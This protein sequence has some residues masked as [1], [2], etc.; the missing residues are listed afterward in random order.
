[1]YTVHANDV[2]LCRGTN[3]CTGRISAFQDCDNV[4]RCEERG[5]RMPL[6]YRD[7]RVAMCFDDVHF[8]QT[9]MTALV[10]IWSRLSTLA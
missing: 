4:V 2:L 3:P 1:M 7:S 10:H 9:L 8:Q 6:N 5:C